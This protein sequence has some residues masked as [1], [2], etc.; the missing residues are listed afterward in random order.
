ME[1]DGD[2][3]EGFEA[4]LFYLRHRVRRHSRY[5]RLLRHAVHQLRQP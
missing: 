5:Y 2:E 1:M 4:L 3:D